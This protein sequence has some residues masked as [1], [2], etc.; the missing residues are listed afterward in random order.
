MTESTDGVEWTRRDRI[1]ARLD[2]MVSAGRL[3][4]GE[5]ARLRGAADAAEFA[6]ALRDVRLRHAG[7]QLDAALAQGNMTRAEADDVLAR[8]RDGEHGGSLRA[9]VH[10]LR[11][12]G[13]RHR[14]GGT[15]DGHGTG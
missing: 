9:R 11:G 1:L 3:T 2:V 8:I 15:A 5:A 6:A 7:M 13:A 4:A 12:D 14:G 10:R